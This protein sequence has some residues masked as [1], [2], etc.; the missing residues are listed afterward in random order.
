MAEI[1][2]MVA[3]DPNMHN[4]SHEPK[5]EFIKQL[6]DYRKM[7]T[8]GIRASNVAAARDTVAVMD[9]VLKEVSMKTFSLNIFVHCLTASCATG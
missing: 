5:K 6:M 1:Q 7:Q 9:G 3:D 2:K 8:S 4:L